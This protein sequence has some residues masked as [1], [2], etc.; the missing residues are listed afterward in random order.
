MVQDPDKNHSYMLQKYL[1][2]GSVASNVIAWIDADGRPRLPVQED[3]TALVLIAARNHYERSGDLE[4]ASTLYHKM[5][6]SMANFLVDFR[7]SRTG[8]PLPSQDLWEER[9]GVHAF[10]VATVWRALRDAADFT[11]LFAEP[12]LTRQY[13]DAADEIRRGAEAYLYDESAG[14]FARSVRFDKDGLPNRDMVLDASLAALPYFGMFE[15]DDPRIVSTMKAVE[16][17]LTVPGAHGGLAR[18]E[19]DTYQL[20]NSRSDS[21]G[22]GNPW[23]L[24]TLWLAQYQLL[25]AKGLEDLSGPLAILERV[26]GAALPSGVLAEQT[27]P[28]SG[29][30]AGATPLTWAHGT[31]VLTV[32]EYLR[33]RTR[34]AQEPSPADASERNH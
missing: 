15:A 14:R 28:A 22:A 9:Q 19:G 8:L 23:F 29:E 30:P 10:T 20:R 26:S 17:K 12:A 34:L 7:D 5:I 1:P 33:T 31:F 21:T 6:T 25:R 18:F 2:N 3:E 32:L 16:A 4:F 13:L 11:E 27:D 24:C